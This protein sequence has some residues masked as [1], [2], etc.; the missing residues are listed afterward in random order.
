MSTI[1]V[2]VMVEWAKV[3]Q[4]PP[5]HQLVVLS[6]GWAT[7]CHSTLNGVHHNPFFFTGNHYIFFG[8]V[9]LGCFF[10]GPDFTHNYPIHLLTLISIVPT[11]VPYLSSPIDI[12]TLITSYPTDLTTILTTYLTNLATLLTTYFIN[13]T[14]L[15]T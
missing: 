14:S 4:Q 3:S 15:L 6:I 7:F 1:I 5:M 10:L 13:L 8:G 9:V 12:T 2:E 11:L